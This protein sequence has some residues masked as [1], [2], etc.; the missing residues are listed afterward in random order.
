MKQLISKTANGKIFKCNKCNAIHV[1]FK[2]IAFNLNKKQFSSFV[3]SILDLDGTEWE[4][5][6]EKSY[7]SRKIIIPTGNNS[8]NIL[9]NNKE[10]NE[11]KELL[12]NQT[13]TKAIFRSISHDNFQSSL[14]LN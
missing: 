7:F 10:L 6:N 4:K 1:E 2:N 8:I 3:D 5:R 13:G 9:L 14:F 12:T 11:L